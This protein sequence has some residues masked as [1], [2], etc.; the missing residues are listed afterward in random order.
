MAIF[1]LGTTDK[2]L[3]AVHRAQVE[4]ERTAAYKA[5]LAFTSGRSDQNDMAVFMEDWA[6]CLSATDD[7]GEPMDIQK[8][9]MAIRNITIDAKAKHESEV[10]TFSTN[11]SINEEIEASSKGMPLPAFITFKTVPFRGVKERDFP[12]RVN[13][14]I[15]RGE[16]TFNMKIT[17]LD[18][19][20]EEIIAEF[21]SLIEDALDDGTLTYT[22][23]FKTHGDHR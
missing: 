23:F 8:A 20:M 17:N 5:L 3:H 10:R 18:L 12:M 14:A 15:Q 22:G 16:I 4:L 9:I 6:F 19:I 11:K 7:A 13:A 21:R 2:P 1:D